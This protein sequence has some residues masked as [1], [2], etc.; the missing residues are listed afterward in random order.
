MPL[1]LTIELKTTITISMT[2]LLSLKNGDE[3]KYLD[4]VKL[5]EVEA[6]NQGAGSHE[7]HYRTKSLHASLTFTFLCDNDFD[8]LTSCY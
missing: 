6:V 3:L 7:S 5:L 2:I 8:G 1:K 4:D